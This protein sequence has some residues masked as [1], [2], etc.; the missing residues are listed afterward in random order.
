MDGCLET[1][2]SVNGSFVHFCTLYTLIFVDNSYR[3]YI[4]SGQWGGIVYSYI[5]DSC[6]QLVLMHLDVRELETMYL[7]YDLS[8]NRSF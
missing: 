8:N 1:T 6:L 2:L 7:Q 4:S 5:I 3:K